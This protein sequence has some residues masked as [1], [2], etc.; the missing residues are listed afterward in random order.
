[1]RGGLPAEAR[2]FWDKNLGSIR[3]GVVYQGGWEKYFRN[4]SL[5]IGLVRRKLLEAVFACPDVARQ[6]C[7]W[8][9]AWNSREWRTFLR[10]VSLRSV[11]KY[12]FGD[13]GFYR[14]V[15]KDFPVYAYLER[16]FEHAFRN[17]L[18]RES[19]YASMLFLGRLGRA[20]P[21]HLRKENY[22]ALRERISALRVVTRPIGDFLAASGPN[23]FDGY[24][25]SDFSSYTDA[26]E[27]GRIWRGVLRTAGPAARVCERQFMVKRP[28]PVDVAP[29]IGRDPELERELEKTDD[30]LF[31]SFIVGQV[32]RGSE[33]TP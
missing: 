27:Y 20:L 17:V 23:S 11:W 22:P 24:S 3:K 33:W 28:L 6:A 5:V 9:G 19:P 25:L 18:L 8:K 15:P 14:Y 30:S 29:H 21:P 26:R 4:L 31:F 16:R 12:A 10:L 1:M 32:R 13:P 2:A 7:L